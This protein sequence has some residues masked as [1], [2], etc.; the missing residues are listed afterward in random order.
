MRVEPIELWSVGSLK[1]FS[2]INMLLDLTAS[3]HENDR[4]RDSQQGGESGSVVLLTEESIIFPLKNMT[5]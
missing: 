4:D 5:K 1:Y 3:D 2:K